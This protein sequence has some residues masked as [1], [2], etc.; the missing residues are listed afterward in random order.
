MAIRKITVTKN[1]PNNIVEGIGCFII[2]LGI[3]LVIIALA[4]A[5]NFKEILEI[6]KHWH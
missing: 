5:S 6:L 3:A 1:P 4:I 2:L